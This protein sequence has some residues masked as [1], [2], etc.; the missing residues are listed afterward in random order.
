M[1][2]SRS[3]N[4]AAAC[5]TRSRCHGSMI[6][7]AQSGSRPTME[8]TFSRAALAIGITQNVVVETVFFVPH[9]VRSHLIHRLGNP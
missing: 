3:R 1:R 4:I 8:R 2:W 5:G 7:V 9:A 6:V